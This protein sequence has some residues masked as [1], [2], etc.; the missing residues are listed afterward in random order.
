MKYLNILSY[1]LNFIFIIVLFFKSA[2]NDI[3]K[4]RYKE[5]RESKRNKI[6]KLKI[7]RTNVEKLKPLSLIMMLDIRD[8]ELNKNVPD[9]NELLVR[10]RR[11][12]KNWGDIYDSILTDKADYPA[13][14][15]KL[16]EIFF[17][18]IQ[19]N[20]GGMLSKIPTND[21]MRNMHNELEN[22]LNNLIESIDVKI[23]SK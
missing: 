23:N 12:R 13:D 19:N 14:I 6:N 3:L 1:L 2:I 22:I 10:V 9:F 18:N 21:E 15:V 4:E 5:W 17:E 16:I 7:L 11:N 20:N 8:I